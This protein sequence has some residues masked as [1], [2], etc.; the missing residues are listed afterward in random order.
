MRIAAFAI[1]AA[2]ALA[3]C[4]K[5][6]SSR[7]AVDLGDKRAKL[8]AYKEAVRAYE[9][10]FDGTAKTAEVHYKLGVLYDD[11]LKN[12]LA[13]I[14]HYDRYLDLVPTGG[15][16]KEAKAARADCEKRLNLSLK[17]G[18]LMTTSE[19]ARLRNEN[20]RLRKELAELHSIKPT[21]APH[22]AGAGGTDKMTP[23]ARTHVV[24]RGETLA[25]ISFK[26]YRNRANASRIKTANYNQLGG[27]DIIK[28]GM[29]L[30]IPDMS[31]KKK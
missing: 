12:P 6:D 21:P 17:D 18:G 11:K 24:E 19:A 7:E 10:A 16:A 2:L 25:S 3:G 29:T 27:K 5:H 22:T 28:P 14:H 23:G 1:A 20:E 30:I 13:A 26:Y 15:R 4:E 31:K 9:S 8:G